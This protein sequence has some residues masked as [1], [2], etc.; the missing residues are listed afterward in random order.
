MNVLYKII[1]TLMDSFISKNFKIPVIGEEDDTTTT[2]SDDDEMN[3][4][5]LY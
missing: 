2:T 4:I 5:I 1:S 3:K